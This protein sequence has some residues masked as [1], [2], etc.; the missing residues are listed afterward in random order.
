MFAGMLLKIHFDCKLKS[1]TE[2]KFLGFYYRSLIRHLPEQYRLFSGRS[3]NTEK[4]E[5]QFNALKTF[6]NLTSNHHPENVIFN[7]IIRFQTQQVLNER[8]NDY[9]EKELTFLKLY[10]PI[11]VT[12]YCSLIPFEW[13]EKLATCYQVLLQQISDYLLCY[14]KCWQKTDDCVVF[15]DIN[16]T[17]IDIRLHQFCSSSVV[18]V[19]KYI[20]DC[21]KNC[22][23]LIFAYKIEVYKKG[24]E[25]YQTL[26]LQTLK[27]FEPYL[28][29]Y[30]NETTSDNTL[31][32]ISLNNVSL[33]NSLSK[34][35]NKTSDFPIAENS[36]IAVTVSFCAV[37]HDMNNSISPAIAQKLLNSTPKT[38]LASTPE[39]KIQYK[40]TKQMIYMQPIKNTYGKT[41]QNLIKIFREK[42]FITKFD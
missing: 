9:Y 34:T 35:N 27:H 29:E 14:I 40:N 30:N 22:H 15:F 1:E 26:K 39:P 4:E 18:S 31:S 24:S 10:Q 17:R 3:S 7:S 41:S 8:E 6:T 13:I 36:I 5:A 21:L 23:S 12:L 32:L 2:L 19:C 42:D 16:Q 38:N 11:N 25:K 37:S 28:S 20:Q 33:S